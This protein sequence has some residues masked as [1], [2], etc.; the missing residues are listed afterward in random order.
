MGITTLGRI[1]KPVVLAVGG[2]A[3]VA[4]SFFG[5]LFILDHVRYPTLQYPD[6]VRAAH[7]ASLKTALERYRSAQGSYPFPFPGNS[8][9]DL[10]K[11]L[12][13][14]KYLDAI[15]KDPDPNPDTQYHY[16]SNDGKV[17]GLLFYLK[18]PVGNI[19]AGGGCVTG[20]GTAGSGWWGQPPECPF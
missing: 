14:G 4:I 1:G 3:V 16:V 15:P 9:I 6:S 18:F 7:A 5:T 11:Q 19:P 17:Y 13:D 10:K 12:V 20:V 2:A 8:V